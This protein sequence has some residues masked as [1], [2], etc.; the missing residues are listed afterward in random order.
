M[1]QTIFALL[2]GINN[3]ASPTVPDLGGCVNDVKAMASVLRDIFSVP[4]SQIKILTNEQATY[5]AVK[6]HFRQHLIEAVHNFVKENHAIDAE[7]PA[8]LFHFSGHG[9]LAPDPTGQEPDGFD[10]TL[11]CY[12]SRL[13]GIYDLKDW[14][15]GGLLKELAQYTD[16]VTVILDCCHS[17][18][19]TRSETKVVTHT[20]NCYPD[21]RVQPVDRSVA[22]NVGP[23][24]NDTLK[25]LHQGST[26]ASHHWLRGAA[27]HV[28]LAACR[29]QEQAREYIPTPA[30][31]AE[32][33]IQPAQRHGVLTY[34]L[35]KLLTELD[36]QQPP[37]YRELHET[38]RYLVQRNYA[39]TPQCEGD[40]GRLLF[41]GSR[42]DR[43][44]WLSIVDVRD[45]LYWIN[46]G[47]AHGLSEGTT[48]Q[49]FRPEARTVEDA[50]AAL[51]L[52]EVVKVGA[53][54]SSCRAQAAD[55]A[56]PMRARLLPLGGGNTPRKRLAIQITQ[57]M[58]AVAVRER[59]AQNDLAGL[60][61]LV[62]ADDD[63][64]LR[65]VLLDNALEI[66]DSSGMRI[67]KTYPLQQLNRMHRP[68]RAGDLNP[69]ADDL[70][71]IA[72]TQQ[73]DLLQNTH[74]D[75][76][77]ELVLTLRHLETDMTTRIPRAGALIG[78]TAADGKTG[79]AIPQLHAEQPFLIE[80][81]N[82][83]EEPLYVG[84][85]LRSGPWLVEQVYP[86]VRGAKE[87]L[88]PGRTLTIGMDAE[89]EK[90]LRM[91]INGTAQKDTATFLL[92]G[93]VEEAD[94]DLLLQHQKA[95]MRK[96][97]VHQSDTGEQQRAMRSFQI[98]GPSTSA[99]EWMIARLTVAVIV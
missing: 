21:V 92:I 41:G 59:L 5:N 26:P 17:G 25:P 28:L 40:W 33:Q 24:Y 53:V 70:R 19:G 71:R 91:T 54:Q 2:I 62:P 39:Q 30:A 9:S 3:Y 8:V 89:A 69:L 97:I 63:A 79:Q 22:A 50:G 82:Q 84:L 47:L 10:E 20:R 58:I 66:Q 48:M 80:V 55:T 13:P 44:L 96:A 73:L 43:D 38:L 27:N 11:V 51:G 74:S 23:Q 88:F 61:S 1:Q 35:I 60:L 15:L 6:L 99:D 64:P 57:E 83:G 42:P 93:T 4:E 75:L 49:V 77:A 56:F 34:Y 65:I 87:Q 36:L 18:S 32:Q 12:D 94:F 45:G 81:T 86:V 85:L 29:D 95:D 76:A 37:T 31:T 67:G 68:V 78:T 72:R 90:Q 98:G 14:E 7:P 46:G 16:N 52:L